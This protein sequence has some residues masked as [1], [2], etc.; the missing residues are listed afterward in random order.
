[1]SFIELLQEREYELKLNLNR[2]FSSLV[3]EDSLEGQL[4]EQSKY[5]FRSPF[6]KNSCSSSV[7]SPRDNFF[8]TALEGGSVISSCQN[9]LAQLSRSSIDF[10]GSMNSLLIEP[11]FKIFFQKRIHYYSRVRNST[12]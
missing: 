12:L 8:V 11:S 9:S 4:L 3:Q 1:M 10:D 7:C 5:Y 2:K 6:E